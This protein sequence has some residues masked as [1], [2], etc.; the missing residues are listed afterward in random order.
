MDVRD[1]GVALWRQ[2][3]LVAAVLVVTGAAVALGVFLAPKSY[4]ATATISAAESASATAADDPD[5]LRATLAEL[6]SS[7]EVVDRARDELSVDRSPAELR[8]SVRGEWRRGTILVD[9]TVHDRDPD[10]AADL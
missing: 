8:S 5:V 4:A 9:V 2:R 6:A 10:T 7:R 1:V 3:P